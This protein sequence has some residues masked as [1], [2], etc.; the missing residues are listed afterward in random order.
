LR[1][2]QESWISCS[3][4]AGSGSGCACVEADFDVQVRRLT[5][6]VDGTR[7]PHVVALFQPVIRGAG[8][9]DAFEDAVELVDD[10]DQAVS[11]R[12]GRVRHADCRRGGGLLEDHVAFPVAGR[13][14]GDAPQQDVV[15]APDVVVGKVHGVLPVEGEVEGRRSD[16][17][18]DPGHVDR[19][20]GICHGRRRDLDGS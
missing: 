1:T 6:H 11:P 5:S 3:A 9:V 16:V 17:A 18:H 2:R 20:A 14:P 15:G 10:D 4:A 13:R 19:V 7:C 8:R 12:R